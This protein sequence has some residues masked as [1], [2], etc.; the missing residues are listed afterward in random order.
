MALPVLPLAC[1]WGIVAI[2]AVRQAPPTNT[3][4][5]N[6]QVQADLARVF[7]ALLDADA[8]ARDHLL[9]NNPGA[10]NRYHAA[11]SRLGP[12]LADLDQLIIDHDLHDSLED[13]RQL[14]TQEEH[15]LAPLVQPGGPR[16]SERV[17]LDRSVAVLDRIRSVVGT[18]EQRQ[19]FLAAERT[20]REQRTRRTIVT[21][22][23]VGSVL[24][25]GAGVIAALLLAGDISRRWAALSYNVRRLARGEE[26]EPLPSGDRETAWLDEHFRAAAHELRDRENDLRRL[27]ERLAL[28]NQA[29]KVRSD[30]L[31][32][33]N[34]ELESFS[35]SV[36]HDLRAPLRA[37]DGFSEAIEEDCADQLGEA[38][39]QLLK[40]VRA[41]ATRM[42]LLIDDLLNLSGITRLE[43]RREP[44]D[45]TATAA[46][47]ATDLVHRTPDRVIDVAI[48][49]GLTAEADPRM[50]RIAFEN[51]LENAFKYTS[52]VPHPRIEVGASRNGF[53]LAYYVKDN[54]AG[55]DMQ[56]A[57]KLFGAFQR[58]HHDGEFS[59][60][61]IGLATVQRI[62]QRHGGRIWAEG[63]V[64]SGATFYFTLAPEEAA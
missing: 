28:T 2:A 60:H 40:R 5:R 10:L 14:V 44:T 37:I 57:D 18:I 27:V 24:C 58:L 21:L 17:F 3:T 9:T 29:L 33:A 34:R 23:L 25:A 62:V 42:G 39:R 4:G 48:T 59:G 45:L 56:Y 51:L 53:G 13:L 22:L 41:A 61:G 38:G 55:F 50:V 52:R 11:V 16:V 49:P 63:A 20:A 47:I 35:Y 31:E 43:L 7:S 30:E 36:S 8:G 1:F 32:R 12:T 46:A 26:P 15:L 54:G 19:L 64:N 6:L